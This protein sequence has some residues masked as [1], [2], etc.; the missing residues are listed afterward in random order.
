MVSNSVVRCALIYGAENWSSY[1]DDR[2]RINGTEMDGLRR[3]Q[4]GFIK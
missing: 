1:E 4:Q 2:R 3:Y